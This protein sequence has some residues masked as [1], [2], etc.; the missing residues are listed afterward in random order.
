LSFEVAYLTTLSALKLH[1]VDK[2]VVNEC[3]AING[4]KITMTIPTDTGVKFESYTRWL[5]LEAATVC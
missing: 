3:G 5:L 4:M 1:N 2:R